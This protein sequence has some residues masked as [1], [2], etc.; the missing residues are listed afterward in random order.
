MQSPKHWK[1]AATV[2]DNSLPLEPNQSKKRKIAQLSEE[3]R[4]VKKKNVIPGNTQRANNNAA[5]TLKAYLAETYIHTYKH[6]D[7]ASE[8]CSSLFIFITYAEV[9][10]AIM[11]YFRYQLFRLH[12]G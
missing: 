12:L 9:K 11:R 6:T 3:E 7:Q 10:G 5:R 8:K 4:N 2:V 1:M